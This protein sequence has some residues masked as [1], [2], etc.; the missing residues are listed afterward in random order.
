M[1]SCPPAG[2]PGAETGTSFASI[3][4]FVS[5]SRSSFWYVVSGSRPTSRGTAGVL[6]SKTIRD[7]AVETYSHFGFPWSMTRRPLTAPGAG[8]E[9]TNRRPSVT[10]DGAATAPPPAATTSVAD[11]A[12][13]HHLRPDITPP[14]HGV[15]VSAALLTPTS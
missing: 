15:A 10:V 13:A 6:M 9:P 1:T 2:L 7:A 12:A 5:P 14:V 11:S 3:A 8:T 4:M